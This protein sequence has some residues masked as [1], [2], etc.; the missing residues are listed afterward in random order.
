M[1]RCFMAQH[2]IFSIFNCSM[3]MNH[4]IQMAKIH[5][6]RL[7]CFTNENDQYEKFYIHAVASKVLHRRYNFI[8]KELGN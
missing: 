1:N 5:R 2:F 3:H 7:I 6:L 8:E 4:S